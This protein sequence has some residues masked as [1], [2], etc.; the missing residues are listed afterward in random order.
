MLK[1]LLTLTIFVTFVILH[2]QKATSTPKPKPKGN[3]G[4]CMEIAQ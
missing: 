3:I 4:R 2:A 1:I